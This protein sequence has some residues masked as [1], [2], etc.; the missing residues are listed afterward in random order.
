MG[1]S[2]KGA[3]RDAQPGS[4]S[5]HERFRPR[6]RRGR[7]QRRRHRPRRGRARP[8]RAPGRAERP[9]VRHLVGLHQADPWRVALPRARL[10]AAGA[11]GADRARGAAAHGAASDP[12]DAVRAAGRARHAA[13]LDAAARAVRLRPP[14]RP[15]APA[16]DQHDRPRARSARRAAEGALRARLRIFRLLGRRR[17]AGRAQR[18]RRGRARRGDPHPHPLRARR[19]AARTG[20]SCSK[21]AAGATS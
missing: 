10:A 14:R 2:G 19:S 9:R 18:A 11:R 3:P 12:A 7:H 8:A 20:S 4:E 5:G 13:A 21:C 6:H 17:A 15:Q 16:G 1:L